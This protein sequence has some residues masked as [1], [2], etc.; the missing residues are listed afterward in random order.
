MTT[1]TIKDKFKTKS[2]YRLI[3]LYE[4]SFGRIHEKF[5]LCYPNNRGDGYVEYVQSTNEVT[6]NE[7]NRTYLD[8]KKKGA[9]IT[10]TK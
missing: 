3:K 8:F 2:G 10:I 7:A 9:E 6:R 1:V 5:S 4:D